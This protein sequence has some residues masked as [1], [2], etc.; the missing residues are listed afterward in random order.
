ML[1]K[2][3]SGGR[4]G[5]GTIAAYLTD[6]HRQGREHAAPEVVRG[7]MERTRELIDGIERTWT[8]THG[9]LSFAPE[10]RPTEAQQLEAMDQFER[11]AFAGLD[12]EQ[13]DVTWVRHSHTGHGADEG[14]HGEHGGRVELHVV[15]PRL[16]LT[17]G[18]A[19]NIAPPGWERTF[20][21]LR[22]AL[23]YEHGWARPDDPARARELHGVHAYAHA[24]EGLSLRQGREGVHA[25]VTGLVAAGQVTDRA[26]LVEALEEA[27]LS[28][29]RQGRDYLTVADGEDGE[30]IRMKGRLY[31]RGWTYDAELDRAAAGAAGHAVG[32]D[33]EDHR[34]RAQQA[35]AE[36]ESRVRARALFHA[37]RYGREHGEHHGLAGAG[38]EQAQAARAVVV[39]HAAPELGHDRDAHGLLALALDEP[40]AAA[41]DDERE[42]HRALSDVH[43][44]GADLHGAALGD[45]G[46]DVPAGRAGQAVRGLAQPGHE[47]WEHGRAERGDGVAERGRRGSKRQDHRADERHTHGPAGRKLEREAAH[48]A[49]WELDDHGE[50]HGLRARLAGAVRELGQCLR[51]L[52]EA[53][54]G[55]GERALELVQGVWGEDRGAGARGVR[56]E[57]ALGRA[58]YGLERAHRADHRLGHCREQVDE[59]ATEIERSHAQEQARVLA[60]Q[61]RLR[62]VELRGEA[63]LVS[64]AERLRE[65]APYAVSF[66]TPGEAR[67][68]RAEMERRFDPGTLQRLGRGEAAALAEVAE[69]RLDALCLARAWLDSGGEPP[70]SERRM[71]LVDA[72]I[73]AQFDAKRERL[74]HEEDG[75]DWGL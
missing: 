49:G 13:Y 39:G 28:V 29:P 11:L 56:L 20:A 15:V 7:D 60:E 55:H 44:G 65:E 57:Q 59:R 27:G 17:S 31:E 34:E 69:N 40:G 48:A 74:A 61:V 33:R 47:A 68:F 66:A 12:P 4:G 23:N 71:S 18:R 9:V 26:S 10:D 45:A 24:Q 50:P 35:W 8:Y 42:R 70:R 22:D 25:Y 2:F 64:V 38:P 1:I 54:R 75:H 36:L 73:D 72:L 52:A 21:P 6:P 3:T 41:R 63:L 16:E 32:G 43:A 51:G 14:A 19:L 5:G 62:E 30:R 37:E 67:A 53:V 46:H 58:D